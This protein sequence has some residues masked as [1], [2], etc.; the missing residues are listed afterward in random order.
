MSGWACDVLDYWFGLR[1]E[2]WWFD[3]SLDGEIRQR[4]ERVWEE[5]RGN[6]AAAFL[7]SAEEALAA[8]I[9]LDQFPRNMFRDTAKGFSTDALALDIAKQAIARGYDA[10]LS[11]ERRAF[12]LMPFQHSEDLDDQ[13]R[14]VELFRALGDE[15]SLDFA[16]KHRD[17]VARF[18]RFPHRNAALGREP[19]VAEQ[20]AGE[21]LPF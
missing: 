4:F 18:G 19:T 14:S 3:K 1:P 2:Q 11:P 6:P 16:I 10:A 5:Q 9:L 20:E 17:V 15:K 13:E 7:D 12:L 8:V 21:V